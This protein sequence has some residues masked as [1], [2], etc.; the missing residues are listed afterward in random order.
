MKLINLKETEV[1]FLGDF[2]ISLLVNDKF[3]LKEN[4][5]L[6]FRN[7][8]CPLMSKY[9]ELCQ[10]FSL[11]EIIQEPTRITSNTS[12]LLDL[13]LTNAGWKISQKGV[14]DV[15]ISNHQLIHCTRK[16]LRTKANM[17]NQ[18]WVRSLKKYTPELFIKEFKKINFPNYIFSNVN[19]AYLDLVEKILS[20]VDKIA[21]CKDL[22]IKNNTQDWF[23]DEVAKAIKLREKR[24]KLHTDEDLYKEAKYHAVKLI[25]QK[26]VNFTKKN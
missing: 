22:R 6:D 3:V 11:K 7:L 9:K 2:N 14:I 17:H 24:L 19:I 5:P 26:K 13:I 12:S 15:G 1:Y 20:L 16:L 23:H 18:I 10:T 8:N 4:Q 21:P 25:K